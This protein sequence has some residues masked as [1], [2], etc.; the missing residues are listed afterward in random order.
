MKK[1]NTCGVEKP[2]EEFPWKSKPKSI[3]TNK[4][5]ACTREY[6]IR[7]YKEV[8]RDKQIER[9]GVG[10]KKLREKYHQWKEQQS[11]L[12][13]G[14]DSPECLELHH[15][16]PNEKDMHPSSAV[17]RGWKRFLEEAA[18]CVVVCANCHRKIHK[19]TIALPGG[20]SHETS[21]FVERGSTP[22]QGTS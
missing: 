19:G 6:S 10:S 15:T 1:C 20:S 16:D 18:K 4:C 5:K 7:Y 17:T 3:K 12:M 22:R 11:C 21:N 13:C 2:I 14:E 8:D 9:A